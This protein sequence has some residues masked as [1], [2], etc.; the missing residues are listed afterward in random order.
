MDQ[1]RGAVDRTPSLLT[2]SASW[3]VVVPIKG[4]PEAKSRLGAGPQRAALADAFAL[5]T[6]AAL[7]AA[8]AVERVFVVTPNARVGALLAGLGAVIVLEAP[9]AETGH[10]RLNTAIMQGIAAARLSQPDAHLAVLTGDLPALR[11]AD[12]DDAFTL[13]AQHPRSVVPDAAGVGT[14]SLFARAGISFTPQFGVG[15]RAAHQAAGH[16]VL[17]L[18]S[19]STLRHDVDTVVD[20]DVARA[21]GFGPHTRALLAGL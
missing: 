17:D 13:A 14:T 20:L 8:S 11:P 21:F 18:S 15:S 12:L 10:A 5:D 7:V 1:T 2:G 6:V 4:S 3:V 16:V 19:T 9:G